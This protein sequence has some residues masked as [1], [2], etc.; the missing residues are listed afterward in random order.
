[1]Q[2]DP[3]KADPGPELD[4]VI[5]LR[6]MKLSVPAGPCPPYSTDKDTAKRVLSVLRTG[7]PSVI[8]GRTSLEGGRSWFARYERTAINGTE[9]FG[10]TFALAVCRLALLR[11]ADLDGGK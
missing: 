2:I 10:D 9:V 3:Y 11:L 4:A 7:K 1:L 6:L 8:V 5:H